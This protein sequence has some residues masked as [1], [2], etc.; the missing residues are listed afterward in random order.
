MGNMGNITLTRFSR[1][2]SLLSCLM[3]IYSFIIMTRR[4]SGD[5]FSSWLIW[6][7]RWS[8]FGGRLIIWNIYNPFSLI[9]NLIVRGLLILLSLINGRTLEVVFRIPILFISIRIFGFP[10][11]IF[12]SEINDILWLNPQNFS[13]KI[14]KNFSKMIWDWKL[15]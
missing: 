7:F 6:T 9:W 10:F 4:R 13:C 8:S 14:M 2:S 11:K 3:R 1:L 15:L 5:C 12:F